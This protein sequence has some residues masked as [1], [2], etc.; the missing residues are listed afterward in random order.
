MAVL[1]V[2]DFPECHR[3]LQSILERAG[4]TQS[5]TAASAREAFHV[6]GMDQSQPGPSDIDVILLDIMMPE[7][8]GIEACRHIKSHERLRDIPV[9]MVTSRNEPESVE[10]AFEAGAVDFIAKPINVIE[11]LARLR[12]ALTLKREMDCRK[13]REEDLLRVTHLLEEANRKLQRLSALDA[14]TGIA[15]RRTFEDFLARAWR[16]GQR[17]SSPVAVIMIDIDHFKQYNDAKG[18]L[19]GDECL[20]KVALALNQVVHRPTDLVARYGGEEF[21]AVLD[22]TDV[23]GAVVVAESMQQAIHRLALSGDGVTLSLGVAAATPGVGTSAGPLVAAADRALYQAKHRGRDRL[24][25]DPDSITANPE[26]NAGPIPSVPT[27]PS[28][29]VTAMRHD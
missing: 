12:S 4:Y 26:R 2:D 14:L 16:H 10:A 19:E 22:E 6:L 13:K 9:I 15:N 18:H 24:E 28:P 21:A 3:P 23:R 8:D 1:I 20:K 11:L 7:I 29:P 5:V 25:I 27:S 17:R